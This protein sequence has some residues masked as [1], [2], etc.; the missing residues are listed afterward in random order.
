M[1]KLR[2]LNKKTI[3]LEEIEG[4][5]KVQNY[6]QLCDVVKDLINKKE[7][8][9]IKNSGGNGKTP[10]LY[11]RYRIREEDKDYS[12]FLEELSFKLSPKLN[13][14]YYKNHLEKYKNHREY[15]LL[16]NDFIINEEESLNISVSMNERSFQI[17][18]REKFIQKEDGKAML[19]NLG[20][21]Q[22]YLNYYDTSEPLSY[23]SKYKK[24]KQ[25]VLI[26]ENKDTYFS[27]RRYLIN[28]GNKILGEE[29]GTLIY[30]GGKNINK[31]F[32]DFEISVEEHVSSKENKFLYFGD[33]DY[34]GIVIYESL[35]KLIKDKYHIAPFIVGY[36]KMID[37]YIKKEIGLPKTKEGQNRNIKDIFLREFDEEYKTK[38]MEILEGELYIPQEILNITD[39]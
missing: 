28:E 5:F 32:K 14:V 8:V 22:E 19:K 2:N 27:M 39:F 15:I 12:H 9:Q 13:I 7:I 38:I 30:G 10:T 20:I 36:Q 6:G 29:I 33:L 35:Y 1:S 23:Y 16:L 24:D 18:G 31:A 21:T 17:W 11:K 3:E 4:I 34:E 25:T 26:L 37:K